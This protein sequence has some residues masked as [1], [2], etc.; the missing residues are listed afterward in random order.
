MALHNWPEQD[1]CRILGEIVPA[2]KP[3]ARIIFNECYLPEMHTTS[4]IE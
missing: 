2:L 1:Y 4:V 3:G